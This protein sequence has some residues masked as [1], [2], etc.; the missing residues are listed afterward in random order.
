MM[1]NSVIFSKKTIEGM[2]KYIQRNIDSRLYLFAYYNPKNKGSKSAELDFWKGVTN[3]Y[4]LFQDCA[5]FIKREKDGLLDVFVKCQIIKE[6]EAKAVRDFINQINAFRT[7]F[8][9]NVCMEY[10]KDAYNMRLCQS[11]FTKVLN[12]EIIVNDINEINLQE[13]QWN[14]ILEALDD[15]AEKYIHILSK[16]LDA[17]AKSTQKN[18]IVEAWIKLIVEWYER[19]FDYLLYKAI[20]NQFMLYCTLNKKY[21]K[22]N[23]K[24]TPVNEWIR[25]K[26]GYIS[27]RISYIS[28]NEENICMLPVEFF[29]ELIKETR[30]FE[31]WNE[32]YHKR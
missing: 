13:M 7:V 18:I 19:K 23:D 25:C 22:I 3:M 20:Y 29:N 28:S 31:F 14:K 26:K 2:N 1:C 10:S 15:E 30:P 11:F 16:A 17:V 12:E 5:A 8:S 9:H 21:G 4:G 27:E 32:Y 6:T 24:N